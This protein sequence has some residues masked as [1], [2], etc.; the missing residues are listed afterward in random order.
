MTRLSPTDFWQWAFSDFLS[1]SL[2]GVLAE[3]LVAQA[4]GATHKPRLEWDAYDLETA[5][6]LK[7]EVK[8]SAY[9]QTW[10]QRRPTPPS[11]G[12]GPRRGWEAK[13]GQWAAEAGRSAEVYVF[14]IFAEQDRAKADPLDTG[15]WFFLVCPTP[16][17]N[18]HFPAQK[19]VRLS[20]LGG[21]GLRRLTFDELEDEIKAA[22][23]RRS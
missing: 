12:I 23:P 16:L 19:S 9:L 13:T 10:E 1:N 8:S 2:R 22:S 7:I 3:Y 21:L 14:C 15:Q 18:E 4:I 5:D 17:L 20:A 11:F 6:G